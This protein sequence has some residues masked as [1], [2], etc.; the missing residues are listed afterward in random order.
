MLRERFHLTPSTLFFFYRH[1]LLVFFFIKHLVFSFSL[2]TFREE[3]HF[4]FL[5]LEEGC[6]V[7]DLHLTLNSCFQKIDKGV[8]AVQKVLFFASYNFFNYFTFSF[9]LLS[10]PYY[11][12]NG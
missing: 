7:H 2:S 1:L 3:L 4:F 12:L 6:G 8:A 11:M 10:P 9:P 5:S